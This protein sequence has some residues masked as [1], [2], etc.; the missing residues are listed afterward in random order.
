MKNKIIL[1]R[2]ENVYRY[3]NYPPLNLICLGSILR[4]NGF[5]VTIINSI[6]EK[7]AFKTIQA[8]LN[9]ALVVGI[10][11]LTSEVPDALKVSHFI[12]K[13][14]DIPIIVGGWHCTLF[15]EQMANCE[16][17]DYVIM[18]EGRSI[19]SRLQKTFAKV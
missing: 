9:D 7:D 8:E 11:M 3:N 17:I 15:P 6:L 1:I 16:N 18:G 10:T 12:K 4:K 19:F 14:A 2:P 13:Q 5:D